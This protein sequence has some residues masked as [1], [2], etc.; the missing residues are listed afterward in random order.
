[1]QYHN[2][3]HSILLYCSL[4]LAFYPIIDGPRGSRRAAFNLTVISQP[5]VLQPLVLMLLMEY[6]ESM[7]H[8]SEATKCVIRDMKEGGSPST[9]RPM[10]SYGY[11]Y[12]MI[13]H[14]KGSRGAAQHSN[15][16]SE[17]WSMS[18]QGR[19]IE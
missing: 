7:G 16:C 18:Q 17:E 4:H 11:C 12:T 9:E 2:L 3:Q 10:I 13:Q 15:S 19:H 8:S 6:V 14:T 1:M 5:G